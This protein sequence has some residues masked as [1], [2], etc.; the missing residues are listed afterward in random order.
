ME[1]AKVIKA[2]LEEQVEREEIRL[3]E[4][5]QMEKDMR[6]RVQVNI[7]RSKVKD[8]I[9]SISRKRART[10]RNMSVVHPGHENFNLVFN[11]MLGIKKATEAIIDFPLFELQKKDFKIK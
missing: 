4:N 2:S 5:N 1:R 10:V 7:P 9:N 11:I 6:K 3:E 8:G